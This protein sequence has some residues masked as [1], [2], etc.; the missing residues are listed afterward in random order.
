METVLQPRAFSRV[1]KTLRQVRSGH[2]H[3][4]NLEQSKTNGSELALEAVPVVLL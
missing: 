1:H 3:V 4:P 2:L